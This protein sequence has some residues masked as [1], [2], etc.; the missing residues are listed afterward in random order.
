MYV[1]SLS[2]HRGRSKVIVELVIMA[3]EN[4]TFD[5][6]QPNLL[7]VTPK[8]LASFI[9]FLSVYFVR[10]LVLLSQRKPRAWSRVRMYFPL[11]LA[12][13]LFFFPLLNEIWVEGW[14]VRRA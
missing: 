11:G 3:H 4:S 7:P 8:T 10:K 1:I 5:H 2:E 9:H 14:K 13:F 12:H 6:F